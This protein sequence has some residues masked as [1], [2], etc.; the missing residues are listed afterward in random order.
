MEYRNREWSLDSLT[1]DLQD[2]LEWSIIGLLWRVNTW[3]NNWVMMIYTT[4]LG[5]N[6]HWNREWL[7]NQIDHNIKDYIILRD[8][9]GRSIHVTVIRS[10]HYY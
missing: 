7:A 4:I 5:W 3:S 8:M 9:E 6:I 1:L 10:N 2:R